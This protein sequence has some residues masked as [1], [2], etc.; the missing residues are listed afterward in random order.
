MHLTQPL[1]QRVGARSRRKRL[2]EEGGGG[3]RGGGLRK[4]VVKTAN[5]TLSNKSLSIK[6]LRIDF[7]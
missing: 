4:E 7:A 6:V 3:G 2:A 5:K 1:G